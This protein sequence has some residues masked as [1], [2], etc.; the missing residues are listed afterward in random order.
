MTTQPL[1]SR[2]PCNACDDLARQTESG[3]AYCRASNSGDCECVNWQQVRVLE[4][5]ATQT[6]HL[7]ERIQDHAIRREVAEATGDG[8]AN[9]LLMQG[10]GAEFDTSVFVGLCGLPRRVIA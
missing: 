10:L 8:F 2:E 3:E 1:I 4:D 7:L 6:A 9:A 5:V